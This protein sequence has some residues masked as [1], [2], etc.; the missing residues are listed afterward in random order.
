MKLLGMIH[1]KFQEGEEI[2]DIES[3]PDV[4]DVTGAETTE[5]D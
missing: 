3:E 2:E 1:L 5:V 4:E